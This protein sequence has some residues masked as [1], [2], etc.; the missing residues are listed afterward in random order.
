MESAD[1]KLI[2]EI[3]MLQ[4]E[5]QKTTDRLIKYIKRQD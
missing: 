2:S 4:E 3:E 5:F 1:N